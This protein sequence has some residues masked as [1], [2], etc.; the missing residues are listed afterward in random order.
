MDVRIVDFLICRVEDGTPDHQR[1]G[2]YRVAQGEGG[3][4]LLWLSRWP[5]LLP[6]LVTKG[7]LQWPRVEHAVGAVELALF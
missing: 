6:K 5:V 3:V 2:E 7:T 1:E 4:S